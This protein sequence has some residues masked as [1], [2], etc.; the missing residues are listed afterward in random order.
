[1][2]RRF[3]DKKQ[4]R[5]T[6]WDYSDD[7]YYFITINT[8]NKEHYFGEIVDT[9]MKYSEIG[10]IAKW[11]LLEISEHFPGTSIYC[12]VVMPNHVHFVLG[13]FRR[14]LPW[15]GPSK[16]QNI[17]KRKFGKPVSGSVGIIVNQYKSSVKRYCNK[18]NH[19]QFNWQTNY[20]DQ[21]IWNSKLLNIIENYI[22]LNPIK[23]N[24]MYDQII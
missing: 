2:G 17:L 20:H 24:D 4:F 12:W 10:H 23:W 22:L 6:K 7:G 3:K 9:R 1:M 11:F 21:I 8:L 14:T 19:K 5:Y 16:G 18:N 13:V 15:Q